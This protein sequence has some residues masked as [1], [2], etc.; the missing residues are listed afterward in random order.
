MKTYGCA[1]IIVLALAGTPAAQGYIGL[2][3]S[4]HYT[5]SNLSDVSGSIAAVYVAHAYAEGFVASRLK[6]DLDPRLGFT[7]LRIQH[8]FTPASGDLLSGAVFDYGS[9]ASGAILIATVYL[10]CSGTAPTCGWIDVVPD[11]ASKSGSVEV[12]DCNGY[13]WLVTCNDQLREMYINSDGSCNGGP[14]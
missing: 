2:Y 13:K 3:S 6:L 5:S 4:T 11:P 9:C 8:E 7:I 10:L 1:F 14:G 12:V